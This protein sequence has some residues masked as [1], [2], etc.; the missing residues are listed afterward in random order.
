MVKY[1]LRRVWLSL[2]LSPIWFTI[3]IVLFNWG[4]WSKDLFNKPFPNH[5]KEQGPT[6]FLCGL[7]I[8][9]LFFIWNAR[10][11]NFNILKTGWRS[12]SNLLLEIG[13]GVAM[14]LTMAILYFAFVAPYQ[15]ILQNK[16]GD[17]VE[18]GETAMFLVQQPIIFFIA[19]VLVAPFIEE[20]LFRNY[21][22]KKLAPR[23]NLL[24]RILLTSLGFGL[25]HCMGGFWYM[26]MT[27]ILVG[28][29]F[30]YV[31]EKRQNII[32]TFAAHTTLNLLE[33]SYFAY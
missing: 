10:Q 9:S 26:L 31:V 5:L 8:T 24:P 14:G 18:T 23:F 33:V 6:I 12:P 17:Y 7:L 29:P 25:L 11:D 3:T 32:W 21:A 28:I 30:A 19:N 27:G 4:N 15:I 22:L 2:F 16:F 13:G 1:S 20:S